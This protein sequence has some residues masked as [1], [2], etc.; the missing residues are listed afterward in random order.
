MAACAIF[1]L[2]YIVLIYSLT[3]GEALI[4]E[5]VHGLFPHVLL[6]FPIHSLYNHSYQFLCPVSYCSY[7]YWFSIFSCSHS[8]IFYLIYATGWFQIILYLL[9]LK[10]I[11]S[12]FTS[13]NLKA[14]WIDLNGLL[15]GE[16]FYPAIQTIKR[17]QEDDSKFVPQYVIIHLTIWM[18]RIVKHENY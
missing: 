5:G 6:L 14:F 11:I 4:P 2:W 7:N 16:N 13:T 15:K 3:N 12:F 10:F 17:N 8:V 9:H 1:F 18:K